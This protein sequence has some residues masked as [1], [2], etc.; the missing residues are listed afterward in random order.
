M[1]YDPT[2]F[3]IFLIRLA[4]AGGS[5]RLTLNEALTWWIA[6]LQREAAGAN[7]ATKAGEIDRTPKLMVLGLDGDDELFTEVVITED[8]PEN[9]LDGTWWPI[10]LW[11]T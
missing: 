7:P 11:E 8:D 4:M 9:L 1:N 6:A 10:E 5:L 2:I 3:D